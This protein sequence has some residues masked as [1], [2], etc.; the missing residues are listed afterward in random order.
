MIKRTKIRSNGITFLYEQDQS[1]GSVSAALF[2]KCGVNYEQEKERGVSR[3]V[4]E[5]LFRRL[6]A[7][8]PFCR[9]EERTG[10]DHAAFLCEAAPGNAGP[11]IRALA[12]LTEAEAFT[13]EQIESARADLIQESLSAVPSREDERE[14][15]YFAL[16]SY[17]VPVCGAEKALRSLTQARIEKWRAL[18]GN[19]SNACFILT[20]NFTDDELKKT[21]SFLR[22]LPP[23]PHKSLN[24]RP[25]LPERQFFRTS[26]DDIFLPSPEEFG[27]ITLLLECDL[28][29]TRPVWAELLRDLLTAPGSGALTAAMTKGRLTD[30]VQGTLRYYGGF[31]VLS[32]ACA[33][34]HK[35]IPAA[36]EKLAET[37]AALKDDPPEE[38]IVPLLSR[39]QENRL[40]RHPEGA[41]RAY[42]LGLHNFI[43]YTDD[44]MLPERCDTDKAMEGMTEAAD[45]ILIPDNALFVIH[46]N[47]KQGGN[48]PAIR[49]SAAK[50]RIRLFI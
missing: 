2:F 39:Y 43:L 7:A 36:M 47:E 6:T 32:L 23:Q 30:T 25:L 48:L 37:I 8:A 21:A 38:R 44:I 28:G 42:E 45:H 10:R 31:A 1:A 24:T 9:H 4:Q 16:P 27:R 11:I 49:E 19:R 12:G 26:A 40:Y 29:E 14:R 50:A 3:F 20:G 41:Q 46:Y 22:E 33:V 5:L 18:Y 13:P 35:D 15:L 17:A 34:F